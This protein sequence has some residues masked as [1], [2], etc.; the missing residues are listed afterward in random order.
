[1]RVAQSFRIVS[2]ISSRYINEIVYQDLDIVGRD[3]LMNSL[4]GNQ[5]LN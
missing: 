4:S 3:L 5:F 1:M 2:R